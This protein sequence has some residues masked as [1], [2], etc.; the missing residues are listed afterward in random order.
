MLMANCM[1]YLEDHDDQAKINLEELLAS[2]YSEILQKKQV[3]A[4]MLGN[5]HINLA[6]ISC[7][8]VTS[9]YVAYTQDLTILNP[10]VC[11]IITIALC[12]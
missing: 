5:R 11:N 2:A 10:A 1:K 12:P 9:L 7:L 8:H 4:G 6:Y 3:E